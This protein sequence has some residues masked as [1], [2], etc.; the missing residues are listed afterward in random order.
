MEKLQDHVKIRSFNKL[1]FSCLSSLSLRNSIISSKLEKTS[2]SNK[3][4]NTK[5][6][7]T[8]MTWFI[9]P[10]IKDKYNSLSFSWSNR[11]QIIFNILK[12]NLLPHLAKIYAERI[13]CSL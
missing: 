1:H 7:F 11:Y 8:A 5:P 3:S 2:T 10:A 12:T 4:D 6:N 9:I 13:L